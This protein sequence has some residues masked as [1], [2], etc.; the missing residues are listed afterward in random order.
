MIYEKPNESVHIYEV[1]GITELRVNREFD[2][3]LHVV[4]LLLS[5]V[6][7][8]RSHE[9]WQ[10]SEWDGVV[11]FSRLGGILVLRSDLRVVEVIFHVLVILALSTSLNQID[12]WFD[13]LTTKLD[14]HLNGI[15]IN[16]PHFDREICTTACEEISTIS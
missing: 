9:I 12:E 15:D 7:T 3:T 4:Y 14:S 2:L 16:A 8:H 11:Q 5:W 10:L 1:C 13:A 6:V